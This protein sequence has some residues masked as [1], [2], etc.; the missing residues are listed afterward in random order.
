MTTHLDYLRTEKALA[1]TKTLL[2]G[3]GLEDMGKYMIAVYRLAQAECRYE[4][5]GHILTA[6]AMLYSPDEPSFTDCECKYCGIHIRVSFGAERLCSV[7]RNPSD[8]IVR[9]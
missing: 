7:C 4:E 9:R 3:A 1:H 2:G 6:A 8:G 5:A